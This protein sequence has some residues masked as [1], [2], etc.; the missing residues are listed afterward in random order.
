MEQIAKR[1]AITLF[2]FKVLSCQPKMKPGN[3][4]GI[5]T[6]VFIVY[7]RGYACGGTQSLSQGKPIA[8]ACQILSELQ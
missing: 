4:I 1:I 3:R 5:H 8:Y 6:H 2:L 7:R